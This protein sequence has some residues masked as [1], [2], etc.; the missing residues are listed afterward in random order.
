MFDEAL[1]KSFFFSFAII[2][3][4]KRELVALI[5]SCNGSCSVFLPCGAVSWS[6]VCDCSISWSY[7]L[8]F[9]VHDVIQP[10]I[11]SSP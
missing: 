5:L 3:P 6:T 2:S 7:V 4:R 8:T 9:C 10:E 1:S 11:D